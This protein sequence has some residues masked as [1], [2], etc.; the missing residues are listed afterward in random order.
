MIKPKQ[1]SVENVIVAGKRTSIWVK[2][3]IYTDNKETGRI[4]HSQ[5]LET[6][7]NIF[8]CA[9]LSTTQN[10]THLLQISNFL[11]HPYTLKKGTDITNFPI[12]TPEQTRHI[13]LVNP[14][15]VRHLLSNNRDYSIHYGL[16]KTSIT[17]EINE[18]YW[19]PTPQNPDNQREVTPIW[20]GIFND[21]RYLERVEKVY[22][23]YN[24]VSRTQFLSTFDWTDFTL[25]PEAKQAVETLLVDFHDV[26][27]PHCLEIGTNKGF[28]VQ[29]I[30]LDRKAPV[31]PKLSCPN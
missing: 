21:L 11:D 1:N 9:V 22:P 5:V 18:T 28:K 24:N 25:E 29:L 26:F 27:A 13:K 17:D 8:I 2:P 14:N 31:C 30:R 15:S 23:Q 6:Q 20:K 12:S 3:Q 7:K 19:F 10:N 4:Q 16:L